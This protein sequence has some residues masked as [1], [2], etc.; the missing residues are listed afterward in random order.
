[1]NR[2]PLR[3]TLQLL[4]G[5]LLV[6]SLLL[7]FGG[8]KPADPAPWD[9]PL[10]FALAGAL[11]C[12]LLSVV[13]KGIVSPVLDRDESFYSSDAHEYAEIE[14]QFEAAG[15]GRGAGPEPGGADAPATAGGEG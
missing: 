9:Y 5:A 7:E 10:F 4:F 3:T 12:V 11:G 2:S 14:A 6:G 8:T 1:M 15:A 13:A